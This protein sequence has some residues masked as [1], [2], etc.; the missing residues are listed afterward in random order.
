MDTKHGFVGPT[1]LI[2][3]DDR[4]HPSVR[5]EAYL[6]GWLSVVEEWLN[7]THRELIGHAS[8]DNL[9][10]P[11]VLGLVKLKTAPDFRKALLTRGRLGNLFGERAAV[12]RVL[13]AGR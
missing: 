4:R 7:V 5:A 13:D 9:V 6:D 10:R 3:I 8:P 11:E 12:M 2:R 1:T